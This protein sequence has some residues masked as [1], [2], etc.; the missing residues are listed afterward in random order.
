MKKEAD[1]LAAVIR[2][3]FSLYSGIGSVYAPVFYVT[4]A[5]QLLLLGDPCGFMGWIFIIGP[6]A[7]P[8][9]GA[10]WPVALYHMGLGGL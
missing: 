9:L 6:L 7:A 4:T 2:L 8:L 1:L 5:V 3:V 10:F